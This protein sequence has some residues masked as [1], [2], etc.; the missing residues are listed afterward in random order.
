MSYGIQKKSSTKVNNNN[1]N[2]NECIG[3][4]DS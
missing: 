3:V 2:K 1:N 4:Y